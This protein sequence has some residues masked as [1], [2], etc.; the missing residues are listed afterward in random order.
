MEEALRKVAPDPGKGLVSS[1]R[2]LGFALDQD[3]PRTSGAP[4]MEMPQSGNEL[5]L[6]LDAPRLGLGSQISFFLST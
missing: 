1:Q 6:Q 4:D 3:L 5:S 2:T